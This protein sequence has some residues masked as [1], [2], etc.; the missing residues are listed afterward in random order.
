MAQDAEAGGVDVQLRIDGR[1][2][3]EVTARELHGRTVSGVAEC[4]GEIDAR[5]A[6]G[7]GRI[8]DEADGAGGDGTRIFG[9]EFESQAADVGNQVV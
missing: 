8:Q 2:A 6:S 9:R 4:A 7:A 3:S 5:L 1:T